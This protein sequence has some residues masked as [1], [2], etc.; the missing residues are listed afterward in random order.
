M[1]FTVCGGTQVMTPIKIH[2]GKLVVRT[3]CDEATPFLR[4][5]NGHT[6]AIAQE[7]RRR[8][9]IPKAVDIGCGNGRNSK[10]L[11]GFSFS[12]KSFDQ[13]PDY[14][15]A[16]PLDFSQYPIPLFKRSLNV[17][18][19]QYVLMFFP[20]CK[21]QEL[22]TEAF[23]LC[24]YPGMV[25]IEMQDVKS[26]VMRKKD[27]DDLIQ[28]TRLEAADKGLSVLKQSAGKIAVTNWRH[29]S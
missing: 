19:L 22:I 8:G 15:G 5:L 25:V 24:G 14:S 13:H 9:N 16:T 27:I 3:N 11:E 7:C 29:T 1:K 10:H 20:T 17:V 6:D 28:W 26:G 18:L 2:E 12:V 23:D 4:S 21:R